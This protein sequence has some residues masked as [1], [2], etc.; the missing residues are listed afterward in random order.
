MRPAI[1]PDVPLPILESEGAICLVARDGNRLSPQPPTSELVGG[2]TAGGGNKHQGRL[3][4]MLWIG[5]CLKKTCGRAHHLR[6]TKSQD[7]IYAIDGVVG[8]GLRQVK[9][10]SG[11]G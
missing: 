9:I 1:N 3:S 6:A 7:F 10:R 2:Q 11:I 8:E 5:K 4:Q